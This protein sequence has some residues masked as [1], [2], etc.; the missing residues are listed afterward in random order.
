MAANPLVVIPA[1][2]KLPLKYSVT[3][4]LMLGVF[5][6]RQLGTLISG[7]AGT[8]ALRTRDQTTFFVALGFQVV[9]A[10]VSVYL[11]TVTMRIL[12][13]FYNASKRELGWFSS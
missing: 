13:L 7:G 10:L 9:W 1:M 6:I 3:V 2:M 4:V 5:G 11:L 8:V 12:G